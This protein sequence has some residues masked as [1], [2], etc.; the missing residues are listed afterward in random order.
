MAEAKFTIPDKIFA[1]ARAHGDAVAIRG[2]DRTEIRYRDLEPLVRA[3]AKGFIAAG[4][5]AGD[6]I[7]IWAPNAINW[8]IAAIGA[9]AAGAAIVPLN[10]RLKGREAGYILRTSGAKLLLTV[11]DFL[12]TAYPE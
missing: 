2:E 3:A 6:R 12:G 4:I 8:I 7:A 5:V 11:A 9:Q 10:T 1:A